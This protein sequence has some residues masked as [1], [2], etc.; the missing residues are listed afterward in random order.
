MPARPRV[1]ETHRQE[2]LS[3][4]AEDWFKVLS[5]NAK[6][7][8]PY[9][10]YTNALRTR[11]WT[12]LEPGVIDNKYYV[13]GIGEVFEGTMKGGNERFELVAVTHS[14]RG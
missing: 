11:E 6:V 1:G 13:H 4:H 8:V 7:T 9:A 10:R 5:L 2:Y 14:K 12:P 3:G